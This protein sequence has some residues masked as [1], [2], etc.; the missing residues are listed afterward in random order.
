MC[1]VALPARASEVEGRITRVGLF[2]G[3]T[4]IIRPGVWSFVEVE[5][6]TRGEKP[7]DGQLRVDQLDRD[8]DVATSVLP[9]ALAPGADWRPY[10]VYFVPYDQIQ[11]NDLKVR[12]FDAQ[13]RLAHLRDETGREVTEL[14]PAKNCIEI[15]SDDFL[16]VDLSTP[17]RL[18]HL[19]QLDDERA[20]EVGRQNA[21][22]VR[23]L[24]PRDLPF[25]AQGL[26]C[27]DAIVWD[28]ADPSALSQQQCDALIEWVRRGGRLLITGGKNWQA[29]STSP[30][31]EV[32]PA[33]LTGITETN[34][35]QDFLAIVP[36]EDYRDKLDVQ[37][38]KRG[39]VRC[40]M[41]PISGAIALPTDE[42]FPHPP[43][44]FRRFL[45]RGTITLIGA[46]LMQLLPPPKRLANL[47]EDETQ[48]KQGAVNDEFIEVACERVVARRLLALPVVLEEDEGAAMRFGGP[49]MAGFYGKTDLFA[50]YVRR[51]I[52]FEAVGT[53]F[54]LFAILFG[55]AYT[56]AA[57]TGSFWYLKRRSWQH[58]AWTGFAAVAIAG[59]IGGTGMVWLLRGFSTKLW[60]TTFVDAHA[61]S[62]Q[63]V[64]TALFGVKTPDHTRLNLRLPSGG[65]TEALAETCPLRVIA[66]SEAFESPDSRFVAPE[67]YQSVLAG[68]G[69]ESVPL[70][71][72][73]KEFQGTWYGTLGGR[74]DGKLKYRR[75]TGGD[76][77]HIKFDFSEGSYLNNGLGFGLRDCVLLVLQPEGKG[78]E[79]AGEQ[80]VV[81]CMCFSLGNIPKSGPGSQL[82]GQEINQRLY[83]DGAEGKDSGSTRRR[84][85]PLLRTALGD[86]G[87]QVR[88]GF[89]DDPDQQTRLATTQQEISALYLLSTFNLLRPEGNRAIPFIR[90]YGRPLDC[91]HQLTKRSAILMG[92][93][94]EPPPVILEKNL[95]ALRPDRSRTIYRL[96]IPVEKMGETGE[97]DR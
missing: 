57:T 61:G 63:A 12:L 30:L 66:R 40:R 21:R 84:G 70:R 34:E 29:L 2:A 90:S 51:T 60:Q 13:G 69:L 36:V 64:A 74:L 46:S 20:R 42:K 95:T 78:E 28:D 27:V 32:L 26:E 6:R 41:K 5:L 43:I 72:T 92:W 89:R 76:S 7:F 56:L 81:S 65:A 73:L 18:P 35:A 31:A 53:A 67:R 1:L 91:T 22:K 55:V 10:Q 24:A 82:N 83:N 86:W 85:L 38:Q 52:G 75:N 71:A 14:D 94:D 4:P 79:V 47:D 45:G 3:A 80:P 88:A 23:A 9:V 11:V 19:A 58:H 59:S 39:I 15:R 77:E 87:N 68:T 8:G 16:V 50:D 48:G 97:R 93:N 49:R 44:A 96:V 62:D 25:R 54:L 33:T 37:Y 17:K